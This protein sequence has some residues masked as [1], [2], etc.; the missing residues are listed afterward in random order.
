[1]SYN[2][3]LSADTMQAYCDHSSRTTV[4][5]LLL[6]SPL[7]L[8]RQI[9]RPPGLRL[10]LLHDIYR[11]H[12][13]PCPMCRTVPSLRYSLG[14]ANPSSN[15]TSP[16]ILGESLHGYPTALRESWG[17]KILHIRGNQRRDSDSGRR[18]AQLT[19]TW[20]YEVQG[21]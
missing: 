14:R 4:R 5:F 21:I 18:A 10:T 15:S 17:G 2:M 12:S 8:M 1:M 6:L 3:K 19:I 7:W 16:N 13:G 20:V 11:L 9:Y